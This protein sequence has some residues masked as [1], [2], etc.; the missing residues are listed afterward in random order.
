M[1]KNSDSFVSDANE[2]MQENLERGEPVIF[3]AYGVIGALLLLGGTGYVVDRWLGTGPW[4]LLGGLAVGLC[5]AF[6][7]LLVAVRH[8]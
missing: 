2:S 1:S 6:Y 7:V 3:A 8:R 5:V 4:G